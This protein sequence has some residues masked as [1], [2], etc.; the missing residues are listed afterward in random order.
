MPQKH[1][2]MHRV[3]GKARRSARAIF[4][5]TYRIVRNLGRRMAQSVNHDGVIA[6]LATEGRLS[7]RYCVM[8]AL[9][10]AIAILGLLLSSPAVIIGAM[11]LSP[12]MSPIILF[13]FSLT[14]LNRA[15]VGRSLLALAVGIVLA[16]AQA[17]MIVWLSPLQ[18]ITPEILART[19]PNFFDLL[20]AVFSGI[21]GAYAVS[22]H[23]GETLVGV[24][25]ATALMPPLAVVGFGVATLNWAV[26][27]GAGGLFMTNMLVIGLTASLVAKMF[28]FAPREGTSST[29]WYTPSIVAVFAFLSIPLGLSLNHIAREA[30]QTK[31]IQAALNSYFSGSAGRIYGMNIAFP[32]GA[33]VQVEA[34]VL[35]QKMR[36]DAETELR[37]RL[38]R[39]LHE[40]VQLTLSQVPLRANQ[41]ASEQAVN[42]LRRRINEVSAADAARPQLNIAEIAA[43]RLGIPLL[44]VS[45]DPSQKTIAV[46]CG[47]LTPSRLAELRKA[48]TGFNSDHP[49]WTIAVRLEGSVLPSVGFSLGSTTLDAN[50]TILLDD[51]IWVL[52]KSGTNSVRVT[53]YSDTSGRSA[54]IN[55]RVALQRARVVAEVLQNSG[56]NAVVA[57]NY[58]VSGS[59]QLEQETGREQFRRA[60]IVPI[61]K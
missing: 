48:S 18:S 33:P 19:R 12:L 36:P 58:P 37:K 25:I 34:L 49:D 60:D 35:V 41:P 4:V 27:S 29:M 51:V 57:V 9:S 40:P 31:T 5:Q 6:H 10:C 56:V 21:A 45:V 2:E 46:R 20:V 11:L 61:V 14:I 26:F 7:V 1:S 30:I 47:V 50:R 13:G 15:L 8:I 53:G 42:E 16:V 32:E 3:W 44:D 39:Q 38:E 28:G 55:R 22:Q 17:A 59:R 24:A 54:T 43:L 23:K 52:R